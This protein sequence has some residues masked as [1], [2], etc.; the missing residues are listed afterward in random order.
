L[1]WHALPEP[2]CPFILVDERQWTVEGLKAATWA[3]LGHYDELN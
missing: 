2:G 3:M 1:D